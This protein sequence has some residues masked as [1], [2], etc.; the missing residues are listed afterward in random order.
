MVYGRDDS[1]TGCF[2]AIIGAILV[3]LLLGDAHLLSTTYSADVVVF[4]KTHRPPGNWRVP[5]G[6]FVTVLFEDGPESFGVDFTEYSTLE[7]GQQIHVTY[8]QSRLTGTRYQMKIV[9]E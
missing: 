6:W 2:V 3:A 7:P 9:E 1:S 5:E 8:D 4:E